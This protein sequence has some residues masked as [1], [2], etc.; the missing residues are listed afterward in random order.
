MGY[1]TICC[2]SGKYFEWV[3][4]GGDESRWVGMSGGG[5]GWV[6]C[7]IMFNVLNNF[8]EFIEFSKF[9]LNGIFHPELQSK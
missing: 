1:W 9:G 6:H 7:L 4:M 2:V 3:G 8:V 5:W